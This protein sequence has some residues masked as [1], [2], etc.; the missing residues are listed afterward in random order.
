MTMFPVRKPR[1]IRLDELDPGQ[2]CVVRAVDG[3]P[4]IV[5]RL[6]E[7]GLVPGTP[8]LFVRRAPL[9]DPC[10]ILIRGTHISIRRSEAEQ[11]HVELL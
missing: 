8:V 5:R 6:M 3:D 10:E 4:P 2:R 1:G 11:V 9:G 7:F